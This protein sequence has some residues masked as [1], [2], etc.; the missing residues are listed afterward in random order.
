M[1]KNINCKCAASGDRAPTAS[2]DQEQDIPDWLE[3]FTESLVEGESGSSSSAS[4]TAPNTHPPHLSARLSN[5]SGGE[6]FVFIFRRI[7]N[8]EIC[9]RTQ[10]EGAPFRRNL[11]SR[12]DRRPQATIGDTS[13]ANHKGRNE[14]NESRLPHRYAVVVQ[15]LTT[16]WTQNYQ[17][18]S[19]LFE[20]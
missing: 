12:E 17:C 19:K 18:K 2:G 13:A 6:T 8:C 4:E 7:P 9:K 1:E 20:A 11:E 15:G 5:K 3:Q 14:D 10:I 16:Q